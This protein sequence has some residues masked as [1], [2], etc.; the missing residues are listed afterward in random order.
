MWQTQLAQLE[1][2]VHSDRPEIRN[3]AMLELLDQVRKKPQLG[4]SILPIFRDAVEHPLDGWTTANA[5]RGIE[6]VCGPAEGLRLRIALFNDPNPDM[7]CP[8]ILTA[9]D[10]GSVP[11]LINTLNSRHDSTIRIAS[12]QAF[13][14]LRHPSTLEP[15]LNCLES[16]ET[17]PYAIEALGNLRDPRAIPFLEQWLGDTTQTWPLDDRGGPMMTV[18][19][20]A[21]YA[22]SRIRPPLNWPPAP[23]SHPYTSAGP[24]ARSSGP[25]PIP[26]PIPSATRSRVMG[27]WLTFV[28]LAAALF[29]IPWVFVLVILSLDK[30]GHVTASPA[31]THFFDLICALPPLLGLATGAF[32]AFAFRPLRAWQWLVLTLGC[33]AC[34]LAVFS[35]GWEFLH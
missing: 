14:R 5:V 32:V 31:R 34:A 3:K 25:P 23:P 33:A 21:Q 17:R 28:P 6:H 4:A 27:Y 35:F 1:K 19:D 15:M 13:N 30:Q 11:A 20:M 18:G 12:L 24:T 26:P 10:A 22:I 16:P 7:A 9:P 29:L 8:A 2:E